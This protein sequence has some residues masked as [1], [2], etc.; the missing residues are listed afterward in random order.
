MQRGQE[1]RPASFGV[2]RRGLE[3]G[4]SQRGGERDDGCGAEKEYEVTVSALIGL[5]AIEIAEKRS[6]PDADQSGRPERANGLRRSADRSP[7]TP[8][9]RAV[10]RCGRL[11]P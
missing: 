2:R 9:R 6:G 1:R 3:E 8:R 10:R 5:P 7:P 11:T 4:K